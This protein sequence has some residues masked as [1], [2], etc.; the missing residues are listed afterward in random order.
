MNP[1]ELVEIPLITLLQQ[2]FDGKIN[3]ADPKEIPSVIS[4]ED[5]QGTLQSPIART[6][7]SV[8]GMIDVYVR[9]TKVS[10]EKKISNHTMAHNLTCSY[11]TCLVPIDLRDEI[12][13]YN[14][15]VT[16]LNN[17]VEILMKLFWSIVYDEYPFEPNSNIFTGIR[18]DWKVVFFYINDDE[19][20]C[21]LCVSKREVSNQAEQTETDTATSPDYSK[22]E[23]S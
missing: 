21:P 14:N 17:N 12:D 10:I 2:I 22:K 18:D 3:V 23:P 9:E 13:V 1:K 20:N 7:Y 8:V 4:G 15:H 16:L 6:I 19:C 5:V 11:E